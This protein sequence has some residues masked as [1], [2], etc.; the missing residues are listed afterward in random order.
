MPEAPLHHVISARWVVPIEPKGSVLEHHSVVVREGRI[1]AIL[2]NCNLSD[3]HR[4]LPSIELPN[5]LV[6]AGLINTHGHAAMSL[7]RGYADDLPLMDWLSNHIWPAEGQFVDETFVHDGTSL[8]VAEMIASGTTCAVDTYFFPGAVAQAM[9]ENGF[10]GQVCIPVVLFPNA[11][12]KSED[13]HIEKG[14]RF[15]DS[16]RDKPLITTAFSPHAPYTVSDKG[17]SQI[18]K[19]AANLQIPIHLHLHET[20][21]EVETA[22]TE[23]GQRPF[24]R[25]Q[26]LGLLSPRL[27]TV[28]MTELSDEEIGSLAK[29]SVHVAHCPQSNMKLSSGICPVQS[30]M[31]MGV[32]VAL[33]TDG[34]AS[35]NNLDL[36]EE[37]RS[38]AFLS[39]ITTGDATSIS[40]TDA[41]SMATINGAR[42]MGLADEIGSLE[43][44]KSADI[45][46]VDFSDIAFQPMHNPL[47]Q[48]IYAASGH[49]VSHTWIAGQCLY[50]DGKHTKLDIGNLATRVESWRQ[51]IQ[52]KL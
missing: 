22:V 39:K 1:E 45:I 4:E 47:S 42:L 11:W 40:A 48:L 6:T 2:P 51:K 20:S 14:L 30:L 26:K 15:Q 13:Q 24:A 5:H 3:A 21:G 50:K 28:H 8:G 43:P 25:I 19:H 41:L 44:G 37:A 23:G 16:V 36:L 49:Q 10:R 27:Q 34:A 29:H 35:N 38:A 31:E 9:T 32:N 17:F 12:A 52:G 33:G 7:L 46:A 18:E